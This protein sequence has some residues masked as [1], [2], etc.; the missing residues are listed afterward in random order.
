MNKVIIVVMEMNFQL[1]GS[2]QKLNY[3][4]RKTITGQFDLS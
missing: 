1:R 2:F 4:F 3:S